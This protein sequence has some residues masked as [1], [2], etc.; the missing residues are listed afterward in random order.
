MTDRDLGQ[1]IAYSR[2]GRQIVDSYPPLEDM[3]NK[4]SSLICESTKPKVQIAEITVRPH[5]DMEEPDWQGVV[6]DVVALG[7][8]NVMKQWRKSL[9]Y[10][11]EVFYQELEHEDAQLFSE[12]VNLL[13]R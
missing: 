8:N 1:Q 7:N 9:G 6:V 2:E 4:F 12:R 3:L 11:L 5:M 13:I 10:G